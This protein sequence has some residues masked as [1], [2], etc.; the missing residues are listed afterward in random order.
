MRE[1]EFRSVGMRLCKVVRRA[2]C[3]L[4]SQEPTGSS[5]GGGGVPMTEEEPRAEGLD[6]NTP[7]KGLTSTVPAIQVHTQR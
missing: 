5:G 2:R 6:Y 4:V 3:S 7:W 1:N